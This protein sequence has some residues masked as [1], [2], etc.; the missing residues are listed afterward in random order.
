MSDFHTHLSLP[1]PAASLP[2]RPHLF[3]RHTSRLYNIP[4]ISILLCYMF[5]YFCKT[6][7]RTRCCR[8]LPSPSFLLLSF[9]IL[10][11]FFLTCFVYFSFHMSL[12]SPKVPPLVHIHVIHFLE[13]LKV[14]VLP[15]FLFCYLF[16]TFKGYY[17]HTGP[18]HLENPQSYSLFSSLSPALRASACHVQNSV[19]C[20]LVRSV[21]H[22]LHN[23]FVSCLWPQFGS[24]LK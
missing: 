20:S 18:C 2:T 10:P 24:E 12:S 8:V 1:P 17:V 22:D 5:D 15:K 14:T 7:S 4:F 3:I 6:L 23:L 16:S 11:L 19:T 21:L 13:L 9:L